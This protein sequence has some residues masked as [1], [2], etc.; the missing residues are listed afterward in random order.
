MTKVIITGDYEIYGNGTG[1]VRDCM[2]KPT[3]K[4]MEICE[5]HGAKFTIFAEMCEYWKFKEY[6]EEL[7]KNLGYKPHV[8]IEDQLQDAVKR[9]HDVQLHLHPQ[10][11]D[12]VYDDGEWNLNYDW[13]RLPEAPNGLGD[14]KDI[15][16]LTGLLHKGKNDLE[17]MLKPI[18]TN[19]ECLALRSGSYCIQPSMNVFKA[20]KKVGLKIDSTVRK[21][22]YDFREPNY[23]DFRKAYSNVNPYHPDMDDI[24]KIDKSN[25]I[26]EVPILTK[27]IPTFMRFF[28]LLQRSKRTKSSYNSNCNGY[29]YMKELEKDKN[30]ILK[31][32][33]K[34]FGYSTLNWDL[35]SNMKQTEMFM[36]EVKKKKGEIAV[37]TGHPKGFTRVYNLVN[38]LTYLNKKKMEFQKLHQLI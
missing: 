25:D 38:S 24:N 23:Y 15:H 18:D 28:E 35:N 11:I 20:M 16:S 3:D 14:E 29:P 31:K 32:A 8:I 13:W 30:S 22:F 9:G 33:K 36:K 21:W 37:M 6:A 12:G 2:V 26:L 19:Y 7:E 27:K 34:L 4:I 1:D 17:K 10:W 5:S